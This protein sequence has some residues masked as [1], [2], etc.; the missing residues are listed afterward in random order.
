MTCKIENIYRLPLYRKCFLIPALH[1]P[2][3]HSKELKRSYCRTR[4]TW[5]ALST[6]YS[7]VSLHPKPA[8]WTQE[9]PWGE[10]DPWKPPTWV[11]YGQVRFFSSPPRVDLPEWV[12]YINCLRSL[13]H[14][15]FWGHIYEQAGRTNIGLVGG[16]KASKMQIRWPSVSIMIT[17]L[18]LV[19]LVWPS[20]M[21]GHFEKGFFGLNF[22]FWKLYFEN[23]KTYMSF[24]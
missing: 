2:P 21:G 6:Y 10:R 18:S 22:L 12:N 16:W 15:N 8:Q 1:H 9:W 17:F 20:S 3:V 19:D 13:L 7:R 5:K 24:L 23:Y 14:F 11:I 4:N